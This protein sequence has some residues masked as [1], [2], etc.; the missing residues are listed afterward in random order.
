MCSANPCEIS[1]VV[2]SS[3]SFGLKTMLIVR[4]VPVE[5]LICETRTI[6]LLVENSPKRQLPRFESCDV[7]LFFITQRTPQFN[8]LKTF[9][10]SRET[11]SRCKWRGINERLQ[12][13]A[14]TPPRDFWQQY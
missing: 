4:V 10:G 12:E 6:T 11:T 8:A 14:V 13:G 3:N 7:K 9:P 5:H 2:Q 1:I